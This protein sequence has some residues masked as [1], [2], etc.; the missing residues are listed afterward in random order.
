M[1]DRKSLSGD[2]R[3][4]GYSRKKHGGLIVAKE[5][6]CVLSNTTKNKCEVI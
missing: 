6:L 1:A 5:D 4:A 2:Q 3:S